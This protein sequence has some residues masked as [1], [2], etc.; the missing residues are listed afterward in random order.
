MKSIQL[1]ILLLSYPDEQLNTIHKTIKTADIMSTLLKKTFYSNNKNT[2]LGSTQ[3]RVGF[4]ALYSENYS[5]MFLPVVY[6]S[7]YTVI[8]KGPTMANW[9]RVGSSLTQ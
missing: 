8:F 5:W 3:L 1:K 2:M 9:M 4:A 7:V 6:L